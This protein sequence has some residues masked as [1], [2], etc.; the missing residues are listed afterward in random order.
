[1]TLKEDIR[2]QVWVWVDDSDES[3]ELSPH[4]DYEDDAI[5]WKRLL[6]E[7]ANK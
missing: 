7:D 1:M 3:I 6:E 5:Q 2:N 4:F